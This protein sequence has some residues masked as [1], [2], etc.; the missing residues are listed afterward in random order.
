MQEL[1]S[2]VESALLFDDSVLVERFIEGAEIAVAV[3]DG[4]VL[5]A[6][7]IE[8]AGDMYDFQAKY[9][10]SATQYHLPAR[11]EPTRLLGVMNLAARAAEALDTRG[12][13]RIDLLV[14]AGM[15]E[16]VLEANTL[17][18]MT[19]SSLL[20]KIAAS[21]GYDF[22]SLCEEILAS[23]RLDSGFGMAAVARSSVERRDESVWEEA[24]H[25]EAAFEEQMG[26][27]LAVARRSP[28]VAAKS[29]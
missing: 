14:T 10:S 13:V 8:P 27:S 28:K 25:E 16:Y 23:A 15:N 21:A 3:L 6:I 7:E 4:R 26:L 19:A 5:G 2:A 1:H 9:K 29:A 11:I 24:A 12:A 20:P 22:A 17:P 18:G